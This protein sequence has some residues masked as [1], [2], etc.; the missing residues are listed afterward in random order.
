MKDFCKKGLA[1]LFVFMMSLTPLLGAAGESLLSQYTLRALEKGLQ[2]ESTVALSLGEGAGAY[3]SM[4]GEGVSQAVQKALDSFTIRGFRAGSGEEACVL[5]LGLSLQETEFLSGQARMTPSQVEV[6]TSLLPGK[7]LA[8]PLAALAGLNPQASLQL[9]EEMLGILGKSLETYLGIAMGWLM[10]NP[11]LLEE[12]AQDIPQSQ[13]R[14]EA[15]RM[16]T[17]RLSGAQLKDLLVKLS[18]AF[19]QDAQLHETLQKL[20]ESAGATDSVADMAKKLAQKVSALQPTQ[21]ELVLVL[22]LDG[23]GT[24]VEATLTLPP[25]FGG[26]HTRLAAQ[27]TRHSLD[28]VRHQAEVRVTGDEGGQGA[29]KLSYEEYPGQEGG[30]VKALSLRLMVQE[31]QDQPV[32]E[33]TFTSETTVLTEANKET[34]DRYFTLRTEQKA[35][36]GEESPGMAAEP[37]SF[38]MHSRSVTQGTG[39][40]NFTWEEEAQISAMGMEMLQW[41]VQGKSAPYSPQDTSSNQVVDL[42][43]ATQQEKD[44]LLKELE[45]AAFEALN[46]AVALLPP[47]LLTLLGGQ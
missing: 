20:L 39:G 22:L 7:T 2:V 35:V 46:Q 6:I 37:M 33:T 19:E 11:G 8:L 10:E 23:Q 27:Y 4:M 31:G 36:S 21:E 42:S 24:P 1:V 15:V 32:M 43:V 45:T 41:R 18:T 13:V 12:K 34:L 9:D 17:L 5:G 44:A 29:L 16:Q 47:E 14:D 26:D 25:L 28:G 3:L 38:Q 40:G 30:D